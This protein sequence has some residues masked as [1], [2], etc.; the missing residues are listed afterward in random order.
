MDLQ[1]A[2]P[3]G[4][5]RFLQRDRLTSASLGVSGHP[6]ARD[7]ALISGRSPSDFGKRL[8]SGPMATGLLGDALGSPPPGKP[9]LSARRNFCMH[10]YT[11]QSLP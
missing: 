10:N 1:E 5:D 9:K 2:K 8:Q 6:R 3:S 11:I 7:C 4:V